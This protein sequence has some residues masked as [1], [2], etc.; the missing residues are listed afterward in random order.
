PQL[1]ALIA[2][3]ST[4]HVEALIT[5]RDT[6]TIPRLPERLPPGAPKFAERELLRRN[7]IQSVR[8]QRSADYDT[9]ADS[10]TITY[11]ATVPNRDALWLVGPILVDIPVPDIT[12]LASW[13][14]V[15][16]IQPRFAHERPPQVNGTLGDDVIHARPAVRTDD[17]LAAGWGSGDLGL[18]DTGVLAGHTM[19]ADTPS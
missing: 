14:E 16:Y 8:V 13:R 7:M 4:G 2:S 17:Y 11:H 18:I 5:F 1:Q 15:V 6:L 9:L 10:L 12:P 19:F 3:G